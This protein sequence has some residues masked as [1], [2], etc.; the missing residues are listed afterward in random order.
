MLATSTHSYQSKEAEV[1]EG[2][3]HYPLA[4]SME[5][6]IVLLSTLIVVKL[7]ELAMAVMEGGVLGRS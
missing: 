5:Q 3:T 2:F 1:L 4:K 6:H 7:I